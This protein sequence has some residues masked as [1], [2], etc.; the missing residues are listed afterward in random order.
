MQAYLSQ[1]TGYIVGFI[2]QL[3]ETVI[4]IEAVARDEKD[5]ADN[6]QKDAE[7]AQQDTG[8]SHT[9][10]S[11]G[12]ADNTQNK[13]D[14]PADDGYDNRAAGDDCQNTQNQ[15][16][17]GKLIP[18]IGGRNRRRIIG[19]HISRLLLLI[20]IVLSGLLR[21]DIGLLIGLALRRLIIGVLIGLLWRGIRLLIRLLSIGGLL[22]LA[23]LRRLSAGR[24]L[25]GGDG[26]DFRNAGALPLLRR[27]GIW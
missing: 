16:G 21:R 20:I 9:A 4:E 13:A 18:L 7:N 19:R 11:L 3:V 1:E 14:N 24:R 22:R 17:D 15:G 6:R 27:A 25:D 23:V 26:R 8:D 12:F 10:R 5:A 2:K